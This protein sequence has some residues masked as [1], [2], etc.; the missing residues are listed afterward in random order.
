MEGPE[1]IIE[2]AGKLYVA[3]YGGWGFGN[4]ISVIDAATSTVTTS[5]TVGALPNSMQIKDGSLWVSC[6]G[7]PSYAP[8]PL[9]ETAGELAK[10]DLATN[11]VTAELAYTDATKHISNLVIEGADA[12]YTVDSDVYKCSLSADSLPESSLFSTTEQGIYGIYSFAINNNHIYVGDAGNYVNNGKVHIY[13]LS[14]A[15]LEKTYSVGVV[16]AGFYFN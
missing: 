12:Y 7:Y 16:P 11:Q 14:A 2:N 5:I 6:S 10:I 8:A 3:H 9:A 15:T 13:S 4:S 1:R